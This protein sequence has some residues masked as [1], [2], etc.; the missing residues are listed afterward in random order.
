MRPT[1][2]TVYVTRPNEYH[3]RRHLLSRRRRLSLSSFFSTRVDL[4]IGQNQQTS[5]KLRF[6]QTNTSGAV[7]GNKILSE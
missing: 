7:N 6:S 2:D 5:G 3:A 1:R 4:F